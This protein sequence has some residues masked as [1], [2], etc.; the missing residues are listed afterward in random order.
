MVHM[1]VRVAHGPDQGTHYVT[2][3]LERWLQTA[4]NLSSVCS[5]AVC[6]ADRKRPVATGLHQIALGT[7]PSKC[8]SETAQHGVHVE[9]GL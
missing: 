3:I 2:A 8:F 9:I 6:G 1:Q 4:H 7:A 5:D